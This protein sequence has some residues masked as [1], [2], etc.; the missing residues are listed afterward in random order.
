MNRFRRRFSE[1]EWVLDSGQ[2]Q[3]EG[4]DIMARGVG[5]ER[6]L[7]GRQTQAEGEDM[8]PSTH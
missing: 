5:V 4:G 2:V 6:I 1:T 8:P 7:D 3:A